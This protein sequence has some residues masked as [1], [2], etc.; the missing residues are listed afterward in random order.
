M[1]CYFG[2]HD[3]PLDD[4]VMD[5]TVVVSF[6]IP[7]VG[8]KFKAPFAAVDPDHGDLAAL[9]ALL[10]FIDGNQKYFP[11]CTFQIF[12]NNINVVNGLNQKMQLPEKFQHLIEKAFNYR[13]KYRF[14]IGW[15][16]LEGNPDFEALFD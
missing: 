16:P 5:K 4:N 8:I 2:S 15:T 14:S 3:L 9:L 10:E 13:Q 6:H 1:E 7:E 12:G 11:N